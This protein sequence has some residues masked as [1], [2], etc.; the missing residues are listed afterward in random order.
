M[1]FK[2]TTRLVQVNVVVHDHKGE[3]VS[4]LKKRTLPLAKKGSRNR[5][6]SFR[7]SPP[8]NWRHNLQTS[9]LISFS[10]RLQ[11][12]TGAPAMA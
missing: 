5:F 11:E 10:N 7:W 4:D 6:H 12:R 9:R 8:I 3:P 1:V 2:S